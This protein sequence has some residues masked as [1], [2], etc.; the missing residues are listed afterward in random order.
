M[1][2][3]PYAAMKSGLSV[4]DGTAEKR[5]LA[6]PVTFAF[7]TD[8][9][10]AYEDYFRD[11]FGF[12]LT[13]VN[14]ANS[15]KLCLF[16]SS[17]SP[18]LAMR[19]QG[20]WIFYADTGAI[21]PT[22][23]H[24]NL[25]SP[26]EAEARV[27]HWQELQQ[28][29]AADSVVYVRAFWPEK[30]TIYPEYMPWNMRRLVRGT[31]S[32]ADQL[33]TEQR[34]VAPGLTFIDVRADLTRERFP[35]PLY[36]KFDTHWNSLGAFWAYQSFFRQTEHI[37]HIRPLSL[38]DYDIQWVPAR[39]GDLLQFIG[40]YRQSFM[41]DLL[42][43]FRLKHPGKGYTEVHRQGDPPDATVTLNPHCGN[44]LK[45]LLFTDS[46][47]MALQPFFAASIYELVVVWDFYNPDVIRQQMPDVVIDATVERNL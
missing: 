28:S 18:V 15:I 44:R 45:V 2:S 4:E 33:V 41:E 17:P 25:M 42:P 40:I 30:Q 24:N 5:E 38:S 16:H 14:F 7:S 9:T 21:M 26:G 36:Q 20:D 29:C 31:V 27:R 22:W 10:A 1:L 6:P 32:R 12:R 46:Y 39:D 47:G 37:F 11:H 35:Y 23:A 8:Y 43:V 13:A 34:I 19:G 3:L